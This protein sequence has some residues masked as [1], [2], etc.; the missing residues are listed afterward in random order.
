MTNNTLRTVI[1]SAFGISGNNTEINADDVS[2]ISRIAS[3]Q[4][5]IPIIAEGLKNLGRFDLLTE[6][7]Q[8]GEAKAVYDYTQRKVSLE[9]ITI[10]L[11]KASIS[12]IPLKGSVLRDYY[13]EPWMRTSS[14]IDVLIHEEDKEKAIKVLESNTSFKFLRNDRH[15]I[16]FVNKYVHLELHFSFE[17]SVNKIDQALAD[18]WTHVV[19]SSDSYRCSFTPEYFIFYIVTH[20]AKH[21][22]QD[23]GIGIRPILDI[24]VLRTHTLFDEEIVKDLF[25]DAGLLGFYDICCKLIN[26][27]FNGSEQ[28]E[29]TKCFEDVVING[30]VFGNQHLKIVKNKRKDAGKNYVGRRVFKTSK[31]IKNYFPKSRK[32]PVLVPYYQVVRWTRLIRSKRSKKYI[33]EFKHA[34]SIDQSEVEK[35]DKLLKAMG[36]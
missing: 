12:Y 35:Y 28:D 17:Y 26:V 6:Q 34:N 20:A 7:L 3:T 15:D 19:A 30:G 8:K 13:P 9:E 4:K 24:Y 18:P 23:G 11:E 22:I 10:A 29:I 32:Y 33:A 27:W 36:L 5:V 14:D 1:I 21:F 16:H 2:V 25:K 31:E